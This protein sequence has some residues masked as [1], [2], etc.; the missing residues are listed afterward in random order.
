[1]L[2]RSN[3]VAAVDTPDADAKPDVAALKELDVWK[4]NIIR[5]NEKINTDNWEPQTKDGLDIIWE[6]WEKLGI[7]LTDP[8]YTKLKIEFEKSSSEEFLKKLSEE[9]K[10]YYS[11]PTENL[12]ELKKTDKN[13]YEAWK[14]YLSI[15]ALLMKHS[16]AHEVTQNN[17]STPTDTAAKIET[18]DS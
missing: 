14:F 5:E 13:F 15:K 10:K 9:Q 16:E 18:E 12:K 1:M 17:N 8:F 4:M 11:K 2:F 3:P 6:D 7:K